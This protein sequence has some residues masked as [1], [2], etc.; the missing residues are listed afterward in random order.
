MRIADEASAAARASARRPRS[1]RDVVPAPH[2]CRSCARV[3]RLL[4][5]THMKAT[6]HLRPPVLPA[7][8]SSHPSARPP[9]DDPVTRWAFNIMFALMALALLY[10]IGLTFVL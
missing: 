10:F 3:L 4:I 2:L 1:V 5:D 9:A 8:A 7:H 6:A